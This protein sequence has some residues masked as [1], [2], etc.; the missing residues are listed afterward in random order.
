MMAQSEQSVV[1]VAP[2]KTET[3]GAGIILKT[4]LVAARDGAEASQT[5]P[6]FGTD[7]TV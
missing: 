4:R 1:R 6:A 3:K 2:P 7:V 5:T